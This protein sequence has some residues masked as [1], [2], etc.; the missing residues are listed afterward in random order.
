MT[1]ACLANEAVV[2]VQMAIRG[3]GT[4][5]AAVMWLSAA[6]AGAAG[7]QDRG[8]STARAVVL[9]GCV[10][11]AGRAPTTDRTPE[12]AP[13]FILVTASDGGQA[14]DRSVKPYGQSGQPAGQR[15]TPTGQQTQA[16]QQPM[17]TMGNERTMETG[18]RTYRLTTSNDSVHLAEYVGRRVEVQG[19]VSSALPANAR[20][21]GQPDPQG[22]AD[23]LTGMPGPGDQS[24][25]PAP[26][27]TSPDGDG[28]VPGTL[29]ITSI[30]VLSAPCTEKR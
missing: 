7:H 12:S 8:Q 15:Q 19:H 5:V 24:G 16:G 26:H 9:Q 30:R 1:G 28:D 22:I 10:T 27:Y 29:T 17:A 6:D 18:V 4:V 11:T 21:D 25:Q 20:H 3:A 2:R 23:P 13:T 14:L